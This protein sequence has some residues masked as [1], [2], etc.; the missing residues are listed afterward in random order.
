MDGQSAISPS[1]DGQLQYLNTNTTSTYNC[2]I[3]V[4]LQ[5]LSTS[6][7]NYIQAPYLHSTTTSTYKYN[8]W[9]QPHHLHTT[10]ISPLQHLTL[11][12]LSTT[13]TSEYIIQ[14][15]QTTT[16]STRNYNIFTTYNYRSLLLNIISFIGL[17]CKRDLSLQHLHTITTPNYNTLQA[18]SNT[19]T[20][21]AGKL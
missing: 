13:T 6:F 5:H 3:P 18:T 7:N 9:V 17:F 21:G 20:H 16:T 14:H 15:L 19:H 1:L 2:N 8:I 11:Q 4:Q 10:A 12:H